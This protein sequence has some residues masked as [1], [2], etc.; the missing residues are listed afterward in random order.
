MPIRQKI[1]ALVLSAAVL[2]AIVELVR[3][4]RLREEYS[5]LWIF[6][7]F[8]MIILVIWYDAL[9]ALTNLIGAVL[10][11]ST[12]FLFGL[13]FLMLLGLHFSVKISTLTDH[14]KDL[15]QQ[16]AL[17][18]GGALKTPGRRRK[19]RRSTR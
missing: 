3:R 6:T 10:P 7:G 5:W 9:V 2:I 17:L 19:K 16:T 11:T 12:L 4:R 18:G 13:I 1:F 15:A 14:V 8:L